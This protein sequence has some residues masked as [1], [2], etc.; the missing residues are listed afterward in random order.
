MVRFKSKGQFIIDYINNNKI[1]KK[2]FLN[3]IVE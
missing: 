2:I 1:K 3:M